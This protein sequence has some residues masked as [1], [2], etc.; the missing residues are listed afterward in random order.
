[1]DSINHRRFGA[2]VEVDARPFGQ[3][4]FTFGDD[5][6]VTIEAEEGPGNVNDASRGFPVDDCDP[7][8]ASKS[9]WA[10]TVMFSDVVAAA[11]AVQRHRVA[12]W[13]MPAPFVADKDHRTRCR[14]LTSRVLRT[15]A[16]FRRLPASWSGRHLATDDRT[17]TSLPTPVTAAVTGGERSDL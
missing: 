11:P 14:P 15:G 7:A 2:V 12:P 13:R 1:V 6:W 17:S 8:W 10:L 9:G 16:R 3:Y 4:T 5:R